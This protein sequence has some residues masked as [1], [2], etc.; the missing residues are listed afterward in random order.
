MP[1]Y[2]IHFRDAEG[3][4][5]ET[6][7]FDAKNDVEA[8]NQAHILYEKS[9]R[10]GFVLMRDTRIIGHYPRAGANPI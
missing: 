7:E 1:V 3:Q 10:N 8:L 5:H 9:I 2:E 6:E 4:I